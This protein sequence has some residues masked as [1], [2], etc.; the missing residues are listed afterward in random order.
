M[1]QWIIL[2]GISAVVLEIS[3]EV[4][5]VLRIRAMY[6]GNRRL[7][8]ILFGLLAVEAVVMIIGVGTS[9][10]TILHG[11]KFAPVIPGQM[12]AYSIASILYETLLFYLVIRKFVK[13]RLEGQ[14][15]GR[16]K[17]SLLTVLVRDSMWAFAAIFVVM[18]VN[19]FLFT[20]TPSTLGCVGFPWILSMLGAVGPRLILNIRSEHARA[21]GKDTSL[22]TSDMHM[23]TTAMTVMHLT[24]NSNLKSSASNT[25]SNFTSAASR[26]SFMS[27]SA[28]SPYPYSRTVSTALS[29]TAVMS[30]QSHTMNLSSEDDEEMYIP[31][32]GPRLWTKPDSHPANDTKPLPPIP[33]GEDVEVDEETGLIVSTSPTGSPMSPDPHRIE[34]PERGSWP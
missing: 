12:V 4:I 6:E 25:F 33:L 1:S 28:S 17:N 10:P 3:T 31:Y 7:V 34:N 19:T 2:E 29:S 14:I 27:A 32:T 24:S 15:L 23:H 8:Q 16:T 22:H 21:T 30:P 9:I 11:P 5:L 18:I 20:L 26:P 13:T